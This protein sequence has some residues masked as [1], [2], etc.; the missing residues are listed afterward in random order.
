MKRIKVEADLFDSK[1]YGDPDV[2]VVLASDYD[3]LR[4][5]LAEM[6]RASNDFI[7]QYQRQVA[8]LQARI[9]ALMLEYCPNEMTREQI[10]NWSKNQARVSPADE[11]KI[12]RALLD[13]DGFP[14]G[15]AYV[16]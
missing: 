13:L 11:A 7:G 8:G 10:E 4:S 14:G 1:W 9:D 5:R 12:K 6:E 3:A 2:E 16:E 15:G